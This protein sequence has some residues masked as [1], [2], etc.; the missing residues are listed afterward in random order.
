MSY[1]EQLKDPRWQRKRL[2]ILQRDGF[3]CRNCGNKQKELHVHHVV[4][5]KDQALWDYDQTLMTLCSDCHLERQDAQ[6]E[7]L[8]CTMM[9]SNAQLFSLASFIGSFWDFKKIMDRTVV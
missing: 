7:I 1:S 3:A 9:L 8:T 2:E 4:Y 6:Y 5:V